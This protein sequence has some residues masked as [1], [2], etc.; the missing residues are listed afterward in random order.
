M[1]SFE[2]D[3]E[4]P[5]RLAGFPL[6]HEADSSIPRSSLAVVSAAAGAGDAAGRGGDQPR[7]QP[8]NLPYRPTPIARSN[9]SALT[10]STARNR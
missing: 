2:V 5:N 6:D 10:E 3:Y 1:A 9:S 8:M 4:V 7:V